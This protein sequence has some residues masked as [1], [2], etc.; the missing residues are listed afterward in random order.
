MFHKT[1]RVL[2]CAALLAAAPM[3]F[4]TP[5]DL[6]TD[7]G[8]ETFDTNNFA[9]SVAASSCSS[10]CLTFGSGLGV[11][12]GPFTTAEIEP[13][14]TGA[15]LSKGVGLGQGPTGGVADFI[16]PEFGLLASIQ[17]GAGSDFVIWEAGAPAESV[18]VSVSLGGGSFSSAIEYA[19]GVAIPADSSSGYTTNS[20]HIDL[21]DFGLADGALIDQ[22]KISGLFTG[23]GGSGPDILAIAAINAGPP[24]N[25]PEPSSLGLLGIGLI[26]ML[27]YR[28][29]RT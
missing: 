11:T 29:R 4:A 20:V 28:R 16:I 9:T 12:M 2:Y 18:L 13:F 10:S 7:L 25:V 23:I 19:T 24:T 27:A 26:G 15:D 21:A 5:I 8:Q 14:V 3:A 17:N 6:S 1:A 22:V